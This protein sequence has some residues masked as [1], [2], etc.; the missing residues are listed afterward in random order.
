VNGN[1]IDVPRWKRWTD[2]L[3]D[4]R[5]PNGELSAD[6]P[7]LVITAESFD[8][9]EAASSVL[10][11]SQWRADEQSVLR[12]LLVLP[13][14]AVDTALEL[15][16]QDHY[17]RVTVAAQ[18]PVEPGVG[19]EVVAL[20]RVQLIDALHVSQERSRMA[21]LAQ[22]LGGSAAGWQVLQPPVS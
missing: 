5:K 9:V 12:H 17:G 18:T 3:S 4:K 15:A 2:R 19:D 7:S 8:D 16:A 11:D 21:G 1:P 22:R 20:A 14:E 6:D 13:S 10:T